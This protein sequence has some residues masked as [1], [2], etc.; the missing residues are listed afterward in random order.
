MAALPWQ[1]GNTL[2]FHQG[3][4]R[5]RPGWPSRHGFVL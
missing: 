1:Q 2:G 3:K 5:P 4:P